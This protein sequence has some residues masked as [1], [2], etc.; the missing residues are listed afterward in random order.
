MDSENMP[1]PTQGGTQASTTPR[2][3][4]ASCCGER[5]QRPPVG[6]GATQ[7]PQARSE[8]AQSTPAGGRRGQR[9]PEWLGRASTATHSSRGVTAADPSRRSAT[10]YGV[11]RPVTA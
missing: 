11:G 6:D 2:I 7:A 5:G 4:P 10:C 8:P 1:D 9:R 3:S